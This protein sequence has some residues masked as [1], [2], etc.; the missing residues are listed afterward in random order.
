MSCM[1]CEA[2][3]NEAGDRCHKCQLETDLRFAV[4]DGFMTQSRAVEIAWEEGYRDMF[5]GV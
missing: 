1:D 2:L 5:E 3:H 4:M